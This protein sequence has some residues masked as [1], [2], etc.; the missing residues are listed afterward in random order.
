MFWRIRSLPLCKGTWKCGHR[1][2]LP[3]LTQTSKSSESISGGWSEETRMRGIEVRVNTSLNNDVR[4]MP[5]PR[6]NP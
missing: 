6:S 4:S 3:S 5:G 2:P 1:R